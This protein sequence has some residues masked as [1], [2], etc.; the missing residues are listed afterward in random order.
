[1]NKAQRSDIL[2]SAPTQCT[3]NRYEPGQGIPHHTDTHSCCDEAI[4][5]LSL[6]SDVVMIFTDC[7]TK[8]VVPVDLPRRSLLVMSGASR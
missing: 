2:K 6:L 5:S 4:S 3:V 1:M 8:D 7:R